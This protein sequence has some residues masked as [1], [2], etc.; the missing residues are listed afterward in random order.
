M[1]LTRRTPT[2]SQSSNLGADGFGLGLAIPS[3]SSHKQGPRFHAWAL[4]LVTAGKPT[5]SGSVRHGTEVTVARAGG[6]LRYTRIAMHA[7]PFLLIITVAYLLGSIPW[8]YLLMRLFRDEDIRATGSG[9]IGAT[10]VVRSGAKG[11]GALTFLLDAAKGWAA[12]VFAT[13]VLPMLPARWVQ[14]DAAYTLH[15]SLAASLAAMCALLGHIFPVWLGFRG[16]KGV[17]TAFGVFLALSWPIALLSLGVFILSVA[18]FRIVSLASILAAA[19]IPVL[20]FALP[21]HM[22]RGE[23]VL[24]ALV[25]GPCIVILKHHANIRRLLAGTEYRFGAKRP[26]AAA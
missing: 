25:A 1:S 2:R 16:G 7:L 8:G 13:G 14:G 22:G 12:V 17:A 19:A 5:L 4:F 9:N 15:V 21:P 18:A 10:N 3:P 26:A 23:A 24:A 6:A 20:A 11:L